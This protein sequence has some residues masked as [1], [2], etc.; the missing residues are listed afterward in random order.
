[1]AQL[2]FRVSRG[3]IPKC[4]VF[5]SGPTGSPEARSVLARDPSL[6][7]KNRCAEDGAA[8]AQKIQTEPAGGVFKTESIQFGIRC[9]SAGRP[10][11]TSSAA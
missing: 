5:T 11:S 1:M 10:I 3:L 8:D 4:P 6:R 7:L 9:D 2:E